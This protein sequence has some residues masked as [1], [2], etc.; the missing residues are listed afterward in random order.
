MD[1]PK[2]KIQLQFLHTSPDG[3][4]DIKEVEALISA[5]F[6]GVLITFND[7][8]HLPAEQ[9]LHLLTEILNHTVEW[10]NEQVKDEKLKAMFNGIEGTN[11]A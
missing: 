6:D 8:L 10:A 9:T 3:K 5:M 2:N 11:N 7:H 4:V 1:K